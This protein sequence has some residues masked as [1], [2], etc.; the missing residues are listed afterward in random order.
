MNA[1]LLLIDIQNYFQSRD[2]VKFD[3]KIIPN[4]IEMLSIARKTEIAIIH[5]V[6]KYKR[7][8]SNWPEAHKSMDTIWCLEGTDDSAIIKDLGPS[9]SETLIEKSRFTCFYRTGLVE[10]LKCLAVNTL[11]IAG[12]AADVCVRFST[13]DAYNEGYRIYW[14]TDCMDSAFEEYEKSLYYM[15]SLT[16]LTPITNKEFMGIVNR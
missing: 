10:I 14:L 13:M 16:K 6:T 4:T 15:K 9:A 5:I 12:Y 8:K 7:D 2:S 1:A 3:K 11:F